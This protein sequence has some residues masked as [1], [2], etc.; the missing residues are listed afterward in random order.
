[1]EGMK[2]CHPWTPKMFNGEKVKP[3]NMNDINN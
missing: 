3:T 1:M 2:F